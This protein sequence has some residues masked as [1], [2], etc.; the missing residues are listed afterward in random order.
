MKMMFKG[1]KKGKADIKYVLTTKNSNLDLLA[2][3]N[4]SNS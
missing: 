1:A 4:Y 3:E 2:Q